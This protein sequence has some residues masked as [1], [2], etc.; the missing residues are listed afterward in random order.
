LQL[1]CWRKNQVFLNDF[2]GILEAR[3][4]LG[5]LSFPTRSF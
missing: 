3:I 1:A 5:I 2:C 4:D